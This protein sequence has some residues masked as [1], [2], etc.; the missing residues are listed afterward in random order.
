MDIIT[1]CLFLLV[2]VVVSGMFARALPLS[3]PTPI[4]QIA[5]GMAIAHFTNLAVTIDPMV[6][7]FLFIPALL[8]LDA[9][10]IPKDDLLKD[11]G[12]VLE[13]AVVLVFVTVGAVGVMIHW[14]IPSMPL[15]LAFALAAI[16]APTDPVAV[17]AITS[18]L[19]MPK[20]LHHILEGEALVND[21]SG[22]SA[23]RIAI[24][25]LITGHFSMTEAASEFIKMGAGGALM[26][27]LITLPILWAKTFVAKRFGEEPGSAILITVL[28]PFAVYHAAEHYHLSGIL[29]A[30]AA[31]VLMGFSELRGSSMASVRVRRNSVWDMIAYCANGVIFVLLGEQFPKILDGAKR[32]MSQAGGGETWWLALYVLA[33]TGTL[34]AFRFVWCWVSFRFTTFRG[35]T[36]DAPKMSWRVPAVAAAA[37][38]RGSITLAGIMTIPLMMPNGDPVPTRDLAILLASGVIIVTLIFA[39]ITLPWLLK[40]LVMPRDDHKDRVEAAQAL[41]ARAAIQAI[42]AR[43]HEISQGMT[44]TAVANDAAGRVMEIYRDRVTTRMEDPDEDQL[45]RAEIE[46]DL[47]LIGIAAERESLLRMIRHRKTP[48]YP[49]RKLVIELD[50]EEARIRANG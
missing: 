6:F 27:V 43:T 17:S 26:G 40:G 36:P 47:V 39:S 49:T 15:P 10:R 34:L 33:I 21:A 48:E 9:W 3:I 16:L 22:L 5:F 25:V 42:E 19:N 31:G 20:R 28:I 2:T 11:A 23:F 8:F 32:A 41:A 30:S 24:A 29:A 46:R 38:V 18:K 4:V 44:D 12:T 37:G 50:M 35:R 7:L 14:M 45:E 1:T 13:L